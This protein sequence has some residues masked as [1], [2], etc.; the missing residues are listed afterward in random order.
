MRDVLQSIVIGW[1][2]GTISG[3]ILAWCF[4]LERAIDRY[5][6]KLDSRAAMARRKAANHA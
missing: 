4:H 3:A 5:R 6:W 1:I 2:A